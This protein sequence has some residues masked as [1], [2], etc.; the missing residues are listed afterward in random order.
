MSHLWEPDDRYK[1]WVGDVVGG[2]AQQ[3]TIDLKELL[4]KH[5]K[6]QVVVTEVHSPINERSLFFY[7]PNNTPCSPDQMSCYDKFEYGV[8]ELNK[9]LIGVRAAVGKPQQVTIATGIKTEFDKHRSSLPCGDRPVPKGTWVQI[10]GDAASNAAPLVPEWLR[11]QSV[12][13]WPWSGDCFHPN[14]AGAQWY[15]DKVSEAFF[16]AAP[17]LASLPQKLPAASKKL[18][19]PKPVAKRPGEITGFETWGA[20]K[21]G[22]EA[23]GTFTQSKEQVYA[24]SFSGKI[25]YRFPAV[26]N[27]YLVFSQGFPIAATPAALKIMVFGDG[28]HNFLNAWVKDAKGLVWQFTF[29]RVEHTGW[30]QMVAPLDLSLGWPNGPVGHKGGGSP[31]YPLKFQALVLDGWREDTALQGVIYVDEL[32]AGDATPIPVPAPTQPGPTAV[33][34]PQISFRTDSTSVTSG[35]CTTLRW[36][37]D[38]ARAVFLDG[39]GVAG[40]ES[41]QVCPAATQTYRLSVTR[42]DG[43]Q[44]QASVTIQV[45]AGEGTTP[46]PQPPPAGPCEAIPGESYGSLAIQGAPSDRPAEAHADANLSLRGYQRNDA[47]LQFTDYGPAVDPNGPQLPGLFGDQRVPTFT[48]SYRVNDWDWGCN[49]RGGPLTTWESTLLGMGVSA[50]EALR[51]PDSGRSIGGGYE[52]LVLYAS[53]DRITLKYTPE[54][55]VVNGYTLHVEGVCV[56]P[57]LLG[58]YQSLNASGRGQLPALRAGQAFGR[59]KGGE[60][61]VA[62][63]GGGVFFDPRSRQDWWRGR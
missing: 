41:R 20:W 5:P 8:A 9:A 61:L 19:T 34:G 14:E 4:K 11:S 55:N 35:A 47:P 6:V 1:G 28:S 25:A 48:S 26:S 17:A 2:V 44:E 15:A 53:P 60:I 32:F 33:A 16:K 23:W 63:R 31:T 36:D 43:G 51:V 39:Q 18:P 52:V 49:C 21:R 58:L 37:V 40:H 30:Q 46:Q 45:T 13:T 7:R 29:G 38:N 24:G 12:A 27:N 22:D 10:P 3:L 59:A 57:N 62:I 42:Q 50:G 56:E 54:D